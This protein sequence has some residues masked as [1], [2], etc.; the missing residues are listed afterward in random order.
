MAVPVATRSA[1]V[2]PLMKVWFSTRGAE[3]GILGCGSI[4]NTQVQLIEPAEFVIVIVYALG[5]LIAVGVPL[6]C[7]VVGL[8]VNPAGKLGLIE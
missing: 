4:S 7:P 6:I 1:T 3:G 8:I 5:A 2:E